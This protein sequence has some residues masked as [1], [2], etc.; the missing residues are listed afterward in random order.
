MIV[1]C[2]GHVSAPAELWVYKSLLLSHRGEHGKR[3]P[4]LTDEEILT[5]TNKKEMAPCGH[6]DMLDRVGTNYQLL[7]PRPFQMMHSE[8]PA[9]LVHW[10]MEEVN[11]L[12][13]RQCALYPGRFVPMAGL[14]Q[15]AGDP[16]AQA[17]PELERCV[18]K[19][20][21][22]GCLINPDPYENSGEKAPPMGDRYWYPL[23]EKMC[24]LD[25][26][27]HIHSASS[28]LVEREPYSLHFINEETT[29][30][31]GL[32]KSTVLDDFPELKIVV[33]HAGGAIPYQ[34]GRFD[35]ASVR[36]PPRFLHRLRRL[37]FDTVLYSR[38]AIDLLIKVV[39]PDR[40]VFGAE[41]PG[42]GSAIN[43]ETGETFDTI[44]PHIRDCDFITED[45]K[46]AILGGNA[47]KLFKIDDE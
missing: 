7:S 45:E 6:L 30:V 42:V 5:H 15:T 23:Y 32:I 4:D 38:E 17:L 39:G 2:H 21:F 29:A 16:I 47:M 33:S 19:M 26:V 10:Y 27:G 44:I 37:Y 13:A 46:T 31:Y 41:M 43:P 36:R 28:R 1:D 18:T 35:S 34:V 22:R 9:K 20:G 8:K 25:V 3:F 40:C 11:D 12:I 14:P 24:E